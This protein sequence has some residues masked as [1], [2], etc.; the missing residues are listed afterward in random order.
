MNRLTQFS[1]KNV[2]ALFIIM[3]MLFVGGFYSSTQLKVENM[4]NV[5]FPVVAV[6]TTYTGAPKDV[7]DQITDP[8][9]KKLA[10]IE[11]LDSM[12]STSSD[13]FSM[14][15]LM[16]KQ[17]VDTDK[18]KQAVQDLLAAVTLPATAGRRKHPPL[19]QH[20]FRPIT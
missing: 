20:P 12:T 4:P 10:N 2:S 5:S 15:I 18:K 6:T 7:M 16:F 1:M 13:N 14:I 19:V 8:I 9:E 17:N 3:I 11:D